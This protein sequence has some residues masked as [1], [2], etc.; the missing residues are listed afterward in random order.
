MAA[1]WW[2]LRAVQSL[3]VRVLPRSFTLSQALTPAI[4]GPHCRIRTQTALLSRRTTLADTR[5]DPPSTR[6]PPRSW[7]HTQ[8]NTREAIRKKP[9]RTVGPWRSDWYVGY[10]KFEARERRLI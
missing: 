8:D 4:T 3:E 2:L 9:P 1:H 10:A 6:L 5:L 7:P